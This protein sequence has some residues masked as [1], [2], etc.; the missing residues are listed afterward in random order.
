MD[1]GFSAE[2]GLPTAAGFPV[3]ES[4]TQQAHT[5]PEPFSIYEGLPRWL[6]DGMSVVVP[7]E[8]S[9]NSHVWLG[10]S[11]ELPSSSSFTRRGTD[12]YA[13]N[14]RGIANLR[15]RGYFDDQSSH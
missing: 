8:F 5:G 2:H 7:R 6:P 9:G 12:E 13:L 15:C 10:L 1:L 11:S 4:D 14:P 3:A